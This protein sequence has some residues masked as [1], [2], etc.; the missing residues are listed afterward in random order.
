MLKFRTM[1]AD[2][3][4]Q[5]PSVQASND[6]V[7]IMF[8][9]TRDPRVTGVGRWLRRASIDELPQLFNV[10]KGDMSLV[11]PRPIPTWVF[12]QADEPAFH[13]RFAVMAGMTG[14]WQA[15]GRAQHYSLMARYDLAY[16]DRWSLW[17][18][19]KILCRTL[20]VV[21]RGRGAT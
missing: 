18:D 20:P 5:R 17:L 12:D 11:G 4:A 2:A 7:G 21:L 10:L 8:K 6:A 9:V 14:L 15:N 3:E 1:V 16:V 19:F 13:R